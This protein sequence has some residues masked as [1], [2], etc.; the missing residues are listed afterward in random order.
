MFE[1]VCWVILSAGWQ[2]L[3]QCWG[4]TTVLKPGEIWQHNELPGQASFGTCQ[5]LLLPHRWIDSVRFILTCRLKDLIHWSYKQLLVGPE[6]P[7][8]L[9]ECTA[10]W[11]DPFS[12]TCRAL[13]ELALRTAQITSVTLLFPTDF[14]GQGNLEERWTPCDRLG[15]DDRRI[16]TNTISKFKTM[17][18]QDWFP[19][20]LPEF[21]SSRWKHHRKHGAIYQN[22]PNSKTPSM[23]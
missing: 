21:R 23:P 7:G 5:I 10:A 8:P 1:D 6:R 22:I 14:A 12:S 13:L 11:Q 2:L 9:T 16:S 15:M 20:Q 19:C 18:P 3:R 17:W 4:D